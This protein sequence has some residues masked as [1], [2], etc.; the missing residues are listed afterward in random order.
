MWLV[1]CP[2]SEVDFCLKLMMYTLQEIDLGVEE[3][4]GIDSSEMVQGFAHI[5]S[6]NHVLAPFTKRTPY[7]LQCIYMITFC[8]GC[9]VS[10]SN[11]FAAC[12]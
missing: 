2:D 11:F 9:E 4:F 1:Y 7:I 8:K 6:E 12:V 3:L 5:L 10:I